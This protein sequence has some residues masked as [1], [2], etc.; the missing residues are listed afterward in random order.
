MND[1][2]E[3]ELYFKLLHDNANKKIKKIKKKL[4]NMLLFLLSFIYYI[5]R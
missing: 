3:Y 4:Q 2:I 1:Y 5:N